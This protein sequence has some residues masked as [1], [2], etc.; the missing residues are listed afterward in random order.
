MTQRMGGTGTVVGLLALGAMLGTLPPVW[1]QNPNDPAARDVYSIFLPAPRNLR[2]NLSRAQKAL[3]EQRFSDAVT[4]LGEILNSPTGDDYF[5]GTAGSKDAQ[6]SLK[7]QAQQLLGSM[8]S[9]GR[10]LYELQYGAE[11]RSMLDKALE[12]G[13]VQLLTDV[14]RRFFHTK[15]GYEATLLL[16]RWQLDQGRPLAGALTLRRVAETESA[17]A[18]YDPELSVLLATCWVHAKVPDKARETL[19]QLKRRLPRAKVQLGTQEVALFERDEQALAWLEGIVGAGGAGR[20]FEV[21]QWVMFRGNVARNATTSGSLPLMNYRWNLPMVNDPQE[22]AKV[23]AFAKAQLDRGDPV[24]PSVQPLAVGDTVV[25]RTPDR[26]LGVDLRSGKRIWVFPWDDSSYDRAA[27][28]TPSTTRSPPANQREQELKQRLWEDNC[29][30]QMSSDGEQVFLIDELGVAAVTNYGAGAVFMGAR[31]RAFPNAGFARPYNKLVSLDLKKQGKLRWI[32]GGES[33]EDEPNLAGAFFLGA[34]LPL[35]GQLYVLA[36]FNGEIRLCCLSA[37]NGALEWK[38]QVALMEDRQQIT[39]DSLRRLAGAS[40][41][42]ADGVLVCPTSGG[43]V[44][45]IDRATRS[46]LWGYQ[47][48]RWDVPQNVPGAFGFQPYRNTNVPSS[49]WLDSS[50]TIANGCVLLTPVESQELHCLDLLTGK[51]R[52]TTPG[53]TQQRDNML[54]VACVYDN[55]AI[56]VGKNRVAAIRLADG[57]NAWSVAL[58]QPG[59]MPSGRGY[60]SGQHY[61]LPT[62]GRQLVK[63]DLASGK[64]AA[65]ATTEITL[66]NLVCYKDEIISQSSDWIA[67]FY[68]SEPLSERIEATLATNP[69]DIW[70]LTRK[71]EILLQAGD[72]KESLEALWKAHR[73][74][75]GND[76]TRTMLIKVVLLLLKDDYATHRDVASK[77]EGLIDQPAQRRELLRLK[78][79]GLEKAGESWQAFQAYLALSQTPPA[80]PSSSGSVNDLEP[81]DRDRSVR[82]D[83]WVQ[84]R[85]HALYIAADE[86]LRAKMTAA[87][88]ARLDESLATDTAAALR[89]FNEYFGFHPLGS[90][91]RLA[92]ADKLIAADQTLEAELLIGQVLDSKD[93]ALAG[94]ATARLAQAYQKAKRPD[95]AVL[96][97]RELLTR[98]ANVVVQGDLTGAQLAEQALANE[99]LKSELALYT[100]PTGRAEVVKEAPSETSDLPTRTS[101]RMTNNVPIGEYRGAAPRG[102]RAG[103]DPGSMALTLRDAFGRQIV[104]ASVRTSETPQRRIYNMPYNS[105]NAKLN[106]HLLVVNMGSEMLAVDGLG[107][108]RPSGE[109]L[110]WRQDTVDLDPTSRG[111]TIFPQSK[112]V[113]NPL[114]GTPRTVYHDPTGRLNFSTGPVTPMGV[115]FQ[116][117]RQIV[118]VDPL[119]GQTLWER[120]PIEPSSDIFGDDELI[121][122]VGPNSDQADVLS[123]ID[124][125]LLGK[126]KVPRA[127]RRWTN[128]GRHVLSWEQVGTRNG[129]RITLTLTDAWKEGETAQIW[130][131]DLPAASR[132][133]LLD[134]EEVALMQPDGKFVV[135]SLKD[136]GERMSAT[137]VPEPSLQWISVQRSNAQYILV[138]S[139]QITDP[140]PDIS[141]QPIMS[142]TMPGALVHGRVYAFDRQTG[143]PQWQT[144]AYVAQHSLPPEQ[145]AESPLLMFVRSMTTTR[146]SGASRWRC[147]VL[148]LDKRDGRIVMEENNLDPGSTGM[149][150]NC[151]VTANPDQKTV[152]LTV[153]GQPQV[154]S[155]TIRLT[156]KPQPPAPPAQT[157]RLSSL[158]PDKPAGI[159]ENV[160]GD[161]LRA[162]RAG[163][164]VFP[165]ADPFAPPPIIRPR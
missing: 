12:E 75:P 63:I 16:G 145:P 80:V 20:S 36:E 41:S 60:Y 53:P 79:Q 123:T 132:G 40:P 51:A 50:V 22:E 70:A 6:V 144:P 135:L 42:F 77:I 157:G 138:A 61:Y 24:I 46:L 133:F 109:G 129:G 137:V 97:Y 37:K 68:Q 120:G 89:R 140:L 48:N 90:R 112:M 73:L 113:N 121:F 152:T 2:Q 32:V 164:P 142:M 19:A 136:G 13:N 151:E 45:A 154:K 83:R 17:A 52:W 165:A 108:G 86:E 149:A 23:K 65:R 54:F 106:G 110:L 115:C 49:H 29:F 116:R 55:K 38:Q 130:K 111:G 156:D 82:P 117:S 27:Q 131:K 31:G 93:A 28:I 159:V 146:G 139:G 98:F 26:L 66:G 47:F 85:L 33:G 99:A 118:C 126:R 92:L 9:K 44:V 15:A 81:V 8:P 119:T 125:S 160:I 96:N 114:L 34:P 162:M 91:A 147:S 87:I 104:A 7:T 25:L 71:G 56:L 94:G 143:K 95:L 84:G 18:A 21:T 14:T 150:S 78:A 155:I 88:Q 101:Q 122:V 58:D 39:N 1:S 59:D 105:L 74:E 148:V 141:V 76:A 134:G 103:F 153:H 3:D 124:G 127:D 128:C 35:E 69:N 72:R 67:S 5:L 43:A 11:A 30:G 64:I 4:E 158:S 161:V 102:L 163:P 57:S 62:T 10:Q 107:R 100:W